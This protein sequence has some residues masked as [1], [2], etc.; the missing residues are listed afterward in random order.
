M[1][2]TRDFQALG[3]Y[4]DANERFSDL[5]VKRHNM[6]GEISRLIQKAT[7]SSSDSA[8]TFD[9]VSF[10]KKA[11]ELVQLNIAFEAAIAEMDYFSGPANKKKIH[12]IS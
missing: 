6:V 12:R 4:V 3:Q 5:N 2:E 1:G 7:L 8:S 9:H 11:E 10:M